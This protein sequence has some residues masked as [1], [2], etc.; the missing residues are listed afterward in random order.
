MVLRAHLGLVIPKDCNIRV[1]EETHTWEEGKMLIFDD[2]YDHEA[3]NDS[4]EDRFVLIARYCQSSL[5]I[6]C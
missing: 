2:S 5:G 4:D 1:G 6:Y 3:W